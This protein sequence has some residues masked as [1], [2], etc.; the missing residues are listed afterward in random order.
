MMITLL[1]KNR[2]YL[3]KEDACLMSGDFGSLP[4]RQRQPFQKQFDGVGRAVAGFD[5]GLPQ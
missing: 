5:G 1:V 4:V 3:H 2:Y